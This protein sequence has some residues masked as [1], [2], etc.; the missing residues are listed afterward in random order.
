MA[1]KIGDYE[2]KLMEM[3]YHL[4]ENQLYMQDYFDDLDKWTNEMK[5]KEKE[6]IEKNSSSNDKVKCVF[7]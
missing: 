7:H 1:A 4:K 6:V 2:K 3:Q 5:T